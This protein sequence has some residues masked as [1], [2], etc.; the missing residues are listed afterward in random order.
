MIRL[1]SKT[2]A[3]TEG[4]H[5]ARVQCISP[6]LNP[7]HVLSPPR[8]WLEHLIQGELGWHVFRLRYKSL[9]RKRYQ[10]DPE[11]FHRLLAASEGDKEL[12]LT[13]HCLTDHCHREIA[14]EFLERLREQ[15]GYRNWRA[16]M[17]VSWTPQALVEM[18]APAR[19]AG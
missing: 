15:A 10:A 16:N 4:L 8:G 11:R 18:P 9:L 5:T 3:E 12:V 6:Y 14:A 13:C 17:T 2:E 19:R 1:M 7:A